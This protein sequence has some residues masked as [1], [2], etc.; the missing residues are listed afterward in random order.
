MKKIE[1]WIICPQL[2]NEVENFRFNGDVQS[3]R[4]LIQDEEPRIDR[5]GHGDADALLHAAR[6][7]VRI[8]L[9]YLLRIGDAH[10][11]SISI[12]R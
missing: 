4:G 12:E 6:E 8:A 7:L 11:F 2:L 10:A 1:V 5:Q 3:G 9:H